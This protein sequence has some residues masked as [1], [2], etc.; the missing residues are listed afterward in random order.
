MFL[1][2]GVGESE[3]AT[4]GRDRTEMGQTGQRLLPEAE[5]NTVVGVKRESTSAPA[6]SETRCMRR[7]S[8]HGNQEIP[9]ASAAEGAADRSGKAG[10]R[11]PGMYT[12]GKS[13]DCIVPEKRSNKGDGE[14]PAEVVEGRRSTEGNVSETATCRTQSRAHV[15]IGL[16]RVRE[17]ARRDR[18]ARFTALMHHITVALLR[19]SFY[20][21]K[22]DAAPGVDGVTWRQYEADLERR[23]PELYR[24]IH[25]G[26]YRA[27]PSRRGY[28]PKPDGRQRPLGIASLEDKIVQHAVVTVLNQIYEVDFCH[29]SRYR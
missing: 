15:S 10:G 13:D 20:A 19:E 29:C 24:C 17:A 14:P 12:C 6:Q 4:G 21:L 26:T 7:S 5:G 11:T 2:C 18:R 1:S 25:M 9:Q 16:G 23:L 27:Q 8:F 3:G 28:I 22:R